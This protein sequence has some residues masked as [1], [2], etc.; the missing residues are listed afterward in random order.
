MLPL[1]SFGG[2][3]L[4]KQNPRH[5]S[6][7]SRRNYAKGLRGASAEP[8]VVQP[9][10]RGRR[11]E[12][13]PDFFVIGQSEQEAKSA[14]NERRP[15]TESDE[16]RARGCSMLFVTLSHACPSVYTVRIIRIGGI[17]VLLHR[18]RW[19]RSMDPMDGSA[20]GMPALPR[21]RGGRAR[22]GLS[23]FR[24]MGWLLVQD[25]ES[26]NGTEKQAD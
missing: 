16:S 12:Q 13:P 14:A 21:R 8:M 23:F 10:E 7:R 19:G 18:I 3:A 24:I 15:A 2:S 6:A 20:I 11:P 1:F 25:R 5:A 22:R 17:L 9:Q 4:G 26:E